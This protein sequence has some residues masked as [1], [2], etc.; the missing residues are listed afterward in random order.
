LIHWPNTKLKKKKEKNLL[1]VET[2]FVTHKRRTPQ[3]A[4]LSLQSSPECILNLMRKSSIQQS[5]SDLLARAGLPD[6]S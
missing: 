3:K 1:H 4:V 6:F 5:F 2:L